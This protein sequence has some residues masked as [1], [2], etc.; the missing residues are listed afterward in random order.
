MRDIRFA[1]VL[2]GDKKA[3]RLSSEWNWDQKGNAPL[4]M[5]LTEFETY[6]DGTVQHSREWCAQFSELTDLCISLATAI[7]ADPLNEAWRQVGY[8]FHDFS[9]E[10]IR[11]ALS[12]QHK[13]GKAQWYNLAERKVSSSEGK[14]HDRRWNQVEDWMDGTPKSAFSILW[15]SNEG[16]DWLSRVALAEDIRNEH[17]GYVSWETLFKPVEE[18]A[19]D[20][21]QAFCA[22]R[23]A[24]R[25][26]LSLDCASRMASNA[27]QNWKSAQ[28]AK[29]VQPATVAA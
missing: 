18:L 29:E 13:E 6:G 28:E 19:G 11:F 9:T 23:S 8:V 7:C 2:N 4:S 24:A 16:M 22:L 25:A 5:H 3:Y 10:A 15:R 17:G 27:V 1:S 26:V 14:R 12:V 21:H 20:W